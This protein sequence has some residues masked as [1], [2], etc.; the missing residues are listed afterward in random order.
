MDWSYLL[1]TKSYKILSILEN[2]LCVW[3]NPHE[4][5]MSCPSFKIKEKSWLPGF[6]TNLW[7]LKQNPGKALC[8]PGVIKEWISFVI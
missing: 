6:Q 4:S 5:F 2:R 7:D 3:N 8:N 1:K